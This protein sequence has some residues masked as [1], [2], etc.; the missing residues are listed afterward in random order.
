MSQETEVELEPVLCNLT[1]ETR[2]K[3][4]LPEHISHKVV[5]RGSRLVSEMPL[6]SH[7]DSSHREANKKELEP[8][9]PLPYVPDRDIADVVTLS[10]F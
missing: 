2:Q 9:V 8:N 10:L 6:Q 7:S 1:V 3:G 5:F 4:V